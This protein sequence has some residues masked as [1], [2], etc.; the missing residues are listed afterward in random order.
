MHTGS[1]SSYN[2]RKRAIRLVNAIGA[3]RHSIEKRGV[4]TY[5]SISNGVVTVLKENKVN[6]CQCG[7]SNIG[8]LTVTSFLTSWQVLL[9]E[10]GNE[11]VLMLLLLCLAKILLVARA[12][13]KTVN[14]IIGHAEVN[15]T[16]LKSKK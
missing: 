12:I 5:T 1:R 8:K 3:C 16:W 9:Q 6:E 11:L 7:L 4:T 13:K 15:F 2:I 10:A 14:K